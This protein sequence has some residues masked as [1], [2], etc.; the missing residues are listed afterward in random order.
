MDRI[1]RFLH[2]GHITGESKGARWFQDADWSWV[3]KQLPLEKL[4]ITVGAH[5]AQDQP[6][7]HSLHQEFTGDSLAAARSY[8]KKLVSDG[9]ATSAYVRMAAFFYKGREEGWHLVEY[10]TYSRGD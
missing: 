2:K 10:E 7:D 1:S 3:R 4:R 9:I 8:A 5:R 6:A